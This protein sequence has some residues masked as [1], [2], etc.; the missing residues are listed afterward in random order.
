MEG[1]KFGE[2]VDADWCEI[3]LSATNIAGTEHRDNCTIKCKYLKQRDVDKTKAPRTGSSHSF[4]EHRIHDFF[5]NNNGVISLRTFAAACSLVTM[6]LHLKL[7]YTNSP[8]I[9]VILRIGHALDNANYI[10]MPVQ[11]QVSTQKLTL[12]LEK[13]VIPQ[14][15][16]GQLT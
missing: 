4:S 6:S 10:R 11:L 16:Q 13:G 15:W 5:S 1:A 7:A 3:E 2:V 8:H 14:D 9:R 12:P